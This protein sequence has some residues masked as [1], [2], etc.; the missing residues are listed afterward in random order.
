VTIKRRSTREVRG[1]LL[2]DK[3]V[4]VSSNAALQQVKRLFQAAKAGHSGSLDPL[5]SGMLP[6]TL[7]EATKM[8]GF[9]LEADK[10]YW[11]RVKLGVTTTTGDAEGA[12]LKT[13]P[14]APPDPSRLRAVLDGFVGRI[15][16]IPPMHSAIKRNGQ[17]LYKLAHK[18]LEVERP[19]REVVIHHIRLLRS[20]GDELDLEISCSKGTYIRTLAEDIGA[21]LGCGGHVGSLRRLTVGPFRCEQMVTLEALE[22]ARDAGPAAL[23][24]H[25]LP[26]E[27]ALH[28]WPSVSLSDEMAFFI[29]RGQPVVVAK[30]PRGDMVKLYSARD[31]FLGIGR[32]MED[33]RIAPRRLVNP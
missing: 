13:S 2:L 26:M 1:I 17:P 14:V 7:G 21:R 16:Q 23:D 27:S 4:G 22:A 28:H 31:R 20:E 29:R 24:A 12:P 19:P 5:A 18:G 8:A 25:L 10:S 32:V 30:A 33:G 11:T 6:I 3:P 9:V 15:E